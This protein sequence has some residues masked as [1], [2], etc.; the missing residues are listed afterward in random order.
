LG[1]WAV[2]GIAASFTVY[3]LLVKTHVKKSADRVSLMRL[4]LW[5]ASIALFLISGLI[6]LIALP[7]F[8]YEFV[9]H[10]FWFLL[11]FVFGFVVVAWKVKRS[12]E[13]AVS[14]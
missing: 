4:P 12:A 13:E 11:F 10:L 5:M 3:T 6:S 1:I 7:Y 14:K 8:L 9:S 2:I